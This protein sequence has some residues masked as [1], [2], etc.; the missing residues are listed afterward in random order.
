V[1]DAVCHRS[2]E[3]VDVL[4]LC[5][6]CSSVYAG[7]LVGL[8]LE[9]WLLA[10][11]MRTR[12]LVL[13]MAAVGMLV[14]GVVGLIRLCELFPMPEAVA[15]GTGL[16]FGWAVAAFVV[17]S[18]SYELGM[19]QQRAPA[20]LVVHAG[21][22]LFLTALTLGVVAD[23]TPA[24]LMLGALAGPGLAVYFLSVNFAVGLVVW[25]R[26]RS[27]RRRVAVATTSACMALPAEFILFHFWRVV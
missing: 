13:G 5:L 12:R 3:H 19:R 26:L 2:G 23:W 7:A 24:L 20:P 10:V 9:A 27:M 25:R 21:F 6:R 11:G 4:P 16:V 8:M 14:Q 1:L 17:A 18:A 15:V 22:W